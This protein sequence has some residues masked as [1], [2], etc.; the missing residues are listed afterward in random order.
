MPEN[1]NPTRRDVVKAAGLATAAAAVAEFQGAPAILKVHAAADQM[2][3]GVIGTGGRGGYLL[4]HLTK[5]TTAVA[6]RSAIW[7][8]RVWTRPPP[9]IGTNPAKYKDYR[10]LLA[11]KNVEAVIIAR[12]AFR[13]YRSP[14]MPSTPASICSAKRAWCSSPKKFTRCGR[15]RRSIRNSFCRSA[16]SAGTASS[17]RWRRQMVDKGLLGDVTHVHAMWHRNPGW[18]MNGFNWRLYQRILGRHWRPNSHRIR[19]ISPTG[20]SALSG[21]RDRCRRTRHL[22]RRP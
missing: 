6:S 3:Y 10:E 4:K 8:T 5:S 13:H 19:S 12:P 21:I 14:R 15:W 1:S 11:D 16:C 2:K 7:T 18:V 22:E 20:F 17:I 9:T